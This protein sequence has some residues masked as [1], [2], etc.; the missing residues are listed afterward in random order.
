MDEPLGFLFPA[1]QSFKKIKSYLCYICF[2][3]NLQYYSL[4]G[5]GNPTSNN[6]WKKK[7]E[8]CTVLILIIC[9]SRGQYFIY[10]VHGDHTSRLE[11]L[12]LL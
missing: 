11:L 2:V 8:E 6:N 3:C 10:H 7:K 5:G 9:L 12:E 1:T 4:L